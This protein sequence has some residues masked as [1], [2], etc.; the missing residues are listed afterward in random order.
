M[1]LKKTV[2][3]VCIDMCDGYVNAAKEVFKN[4]VAIIVDRYHVAKLYRKSLDKFRQAIIAELKR[5]LSAEE[6]EKIK[7]VTTILRS[8]KEF[9]IKEEKE[10]LDD[11]FS[12]S[13]ELAE[14]YRLVRA[15]THIFNS[16][17]TVKEGLSKFAEWISDV[18]KTKLTFLNK[19]IKTLSKFKNEIAN[20]FINRHTSGFV[21]GFNNKIKVLKRRCYG[22]LNLKH[23]F[24]RLCLDTSGYDLYATDIG[25]G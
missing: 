25:M 13:F 9:F 22:I 2:V 1:K 4:G 14:A 15:L 20:Y 17:L 21:E 6:Y 16:K 10:K 12:H 7:H 3:A 8:N 11:V 24:Q 19:F 18:R 23:L 5:H